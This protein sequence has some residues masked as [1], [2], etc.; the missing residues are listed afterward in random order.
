MK[1]VSKTAYYCC[2]VRMQDAESDNPLVSDPYARRLMGDEGLA[3]WEHFK[4]FKKPNGGNTARCF[5]IDQWVKELIH[6]D[7]RTHIF[8][9]GAGLDSR[10]YRLKGGHWIEVDE[11]AM[12]EYKNKQLP[13][14]E[15][16]NP[17]HRISINFQTESL[18]D[19]LYH[20][21]NTYPTVIII[22]GV[23]M[24][25]TD[26]QISSTIKQ[27]Q[28]LFP[29]HLLLCDLMKKQFFD[30][31]SRKIHKQ[32]VATG[33]SFKDLNNHP[34]Q[35][36]LQHGYLQRDIISI[37]KSS[38]NLGKVNLPPFLV[39]HVLK[40]FMMGY[41]VYKFEFSAQSETVAQMC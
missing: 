5:L 34:N 20:Y 12:M 10:A 2:G 8:L 29:H 33:T 37:A 3:Y 32:L 35:M 21:T 19:V 7:P 16:P 9:I 30:V 26:E 39:N 40:N 41:S 13:L 22:E 1:P 31:F 18:P 17:L 11:H 36:F 28:N 6:R 25:L 27:L 38:V 24:Y 14:L 15:C 4:Q 23:I